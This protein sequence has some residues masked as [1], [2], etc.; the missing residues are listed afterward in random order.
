MR[1]TNGI[2]CFPPIP[3]LNARQHSGLE[4]CEACA[5]W[6]DDSEIEEASCLHH[7]GKLGDGVD[8]ELGGDAGAVEFDRALDV[9]LRSSR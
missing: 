5:A 3:H 4:N 7:A 9:G 1:K 2:F 8:V 6:R